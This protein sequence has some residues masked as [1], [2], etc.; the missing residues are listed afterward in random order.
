MNKRNNN[1]P[2]L[3]RR[4]GNE[5]RVFDDSFSFTANEYYIERLVMEISFEMKRINYYFFSS[6]NDIGY[7]KI[8]HRRY[9]ITSIFL[10]KEQ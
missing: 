6:K 7:K 3:E 9:K 1:I 8:N 5:R 10:S 2:R 4:E